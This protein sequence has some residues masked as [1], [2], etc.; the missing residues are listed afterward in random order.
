[1]SQSVSNKRERTPITL[2]LPQTMLNRRSPIKRPCPS[3]YIS[4]VATTKIILHK[5]ENKRTLRQRHRELQGR[6]KTGNK[7][8]ER[9]E[10]LDKCVKR[11]NAI[12]IV[13]SSCISVKTAVSC[14]TWMK[15]THVTL[16]RSSALW[17]DSLKSAA[18]VSSCSFSSKI[19]LRCAR[20]YK[21]QKYF[22]IKLHTE[23]SIGSA[24]FHPC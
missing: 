21:L 23:P 24:P 16:W 14:G 22:L 20:S 2:L 3:H 10:F 18:R 12:Q 19:G 4:T 8:G 11:R 6:L 5:A 15:M 13:S 9:R 7:E 1:M 17:S